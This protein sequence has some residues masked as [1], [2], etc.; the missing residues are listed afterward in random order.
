[1]S[2]L[3]SAA[4][5]FIITA[6]AF[7]IGWYAATDYT[8]NTLEVE[9]MPEIERIAVTNYLGNS[10]YHYISTVQRLVLETPDD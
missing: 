3:I 8:M 5:L 1:M 9:M 6:L 10:D 7:V 4:Y 2:K